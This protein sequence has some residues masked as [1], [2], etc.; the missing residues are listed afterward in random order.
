LTALRLDGD[1]PE[2]PPSDDP[3]SDDQT[4]AD[5]PDRVPALDVSERTLFRVAVAVAVLLLVYS[6]VVA[7]QLLL[8]VGIVTPLVLLYLFWRFVRAHERVAAAQERRARE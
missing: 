7:Q 2:D 3:P 8:W 4:A 5:D 6:V 1:V